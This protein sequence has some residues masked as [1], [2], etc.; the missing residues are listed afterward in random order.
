MAPSHTDVVERLETLAA[1]ARRDLG[2]DATGVKGAGT[3]APGL[4]EDPRP[5]HRVRFDGARPDDASARAMIE[6]AALRRR[7]AT[8][9][10]A[11]MALAAGAQSP[12]Q[13]RSAQP[14]VVPVGLDA[15]RLWD[16]WP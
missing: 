4:V 12:Q 3:R 1:A 10:F 15:Y 9:A 8:A 16:R 13:Q 14:P 11:M 6:A 5:T 2:D 7:V